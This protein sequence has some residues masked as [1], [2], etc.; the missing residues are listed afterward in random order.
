MDYQA[1]DYSKFDLS[2]KLGHAKA[3]VVTYVEVFTASLGLGRTISRD[4]KFNTNA[5]AEISL[6]GLRKRTAIIPNVFD[7]SIDLRGNIIRALSLREHV[8][9]S[10][11]I[12]KERSVK[13]DF[14][15][16]TK[17]SFV[18][19]KISDRI[20]RHVSLIDSNIALKKIAKRY[21]D[22]NEVVNAFIDAY[23]VKEVHFIINAIL[24]PGDELI[25]DSENVNV[26]LNGHSIVD[27]VDGDDFIILSDKLAWLRVIPLGGGTFDGTIAYNEGWL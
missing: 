10:A 11:A 21:F 18:L 23:N 5:Q 19:S 12:I 17:S 7:I 4:C 2:G 13:I 14:E 6:L 1:F 16:E 9:I 26:L 24:N 27:K 20:S 25:I 8:N 15:E 22:A 3:R